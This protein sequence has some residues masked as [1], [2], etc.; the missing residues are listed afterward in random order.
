M[1]DE[2]VMPARSGGCESNYRAAFESIESGFCVVKVLFD[3]DQRSIDYVFEE[4]NTAFEKQTR[5]KDATGKRMREL[6]PDHDQFWFDLCGRVALTGQPERCEHEALDTWYDANAFRI[7]EPEDHRVAILFNDIGARK[8]AERALY[9]GEQHFRALATAGSYTNYRMSPD[10][11]RMYQLDGRGFLVTTAEP[12]ENW[13]HTY[14][15]KEDRPMVF[16]AIEKAIREKSMFELEHRV[17]L[18]GGGVGWTL[19]R[20]APILGEDGEIVEWCGAATDVTERRMAVDRLRENEER[21]R[22]IIDS[23][24]DYAI[25]TADASGKINSWY[26]GAQS[27]FGWSTEEALGLPMEITYTAEDRAA[28]V[29]EAERAN[30]QSEGRAPDVRWHLRKDGARAFIEGFAVPLRNDVGETTGFLKIGQDVTERHR[31]QERQSTLLAELQHRV[32]NILAVVR[33]MVRRTHEEGQSA[34]DFIQHLEGRIGALARTQVLLT[35]GV[36]AGVDLDALIRDELLVHAV[37]ED[38]ISIAGPD[39]EL[40]PKAAEVLALAIHELAT[41]STKFGALARDGARIAISWQSEERESRPWLSISWVESGVSVL[42]AAPLRQ[43]FGTDL[44]SR[45]VPY[46]LRGTGSIELRPGGIACHIAFPLMQ[47]ASI[48]ETGGLKP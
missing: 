32:R 11:A 19:S 33:S 41:N 1:A 21:L 31:A 7:G 37:D 17:M 8:E 9:E 27:V 25:F 16:G 15:L 3:Q 13:V 48:L 20:A 6:R 10:W 24:R 14:I 2:P 45:R 39:V 4:V 44:I 38:Q 43:G 40:A 42:G 47:G 26:A 46:E 5:L 18:A 12:I 28:A 30:A 35:R 29:P 23:A 34:E 22:L 36:D